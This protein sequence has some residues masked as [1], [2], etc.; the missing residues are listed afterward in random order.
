MLVRQFLKPNTGE[1]TEGRVAAKILAYLDRQMGFVPWREL[2]RQTHL[3]D[4][5]PVVADRVMS[6]L[7]ANGDVEMTKIG[8]QMVV[9][10]RLTDEDEDTKASSPPSV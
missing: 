6:V 3:Y 4:L 10:R 7:R 9:R 1:T 8:K 5:G 2:R